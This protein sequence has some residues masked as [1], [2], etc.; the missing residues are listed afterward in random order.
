MAPDDAFVLPPAPQE[1]AGLVRL[2]GAAATFRLVE[3]HGGTRLP[4][5]REANQGVRLAREVGLDAARALS[6]E[7]GGLSVKV[8]LAKAWLAAIYRERDGL[9]YAALARRLRV[10][11]GTVWR[12]LEQAGQTASPPAFPMGPP[13]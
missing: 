10:T 12:W 2:I 5:P 9:S 3:L 7:F 4:V 6:A 13:G 8:P 11:E 1:L